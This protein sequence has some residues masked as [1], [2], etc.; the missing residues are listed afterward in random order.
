MITENSTAVIRT[1]DA[2]YSPCVV[3]AVSKENVTVKFFAGM[4]RD[5]KTGV[6]VEE[7]SVET[8][9]RKKIISMSERIVQ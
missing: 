3:I 4:K 6:F 7:H 9:P 5:R 1:T 8:I 2:I